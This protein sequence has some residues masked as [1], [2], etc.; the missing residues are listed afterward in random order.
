MVIA[1][2]Q[3]QLCRGIGAIFQQRSADSPPVTRKSR[4]LRDELLRQPFDCL[5]NGFAAGVDRGRIDDEGGRVGHGQRASTDHNH[6][7]PLLEA[8]SMIGGSEH[9]P[10]V[11][12]A[13]NITPCS[14]VFPSFPD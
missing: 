3:A 2:R 9:R 8:G 13:R 5:G 11:A 4:G 14:P 10:T 12:H 6:C 1:H 7:K